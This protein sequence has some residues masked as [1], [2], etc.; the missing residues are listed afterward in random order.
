MALIAIYLLLMA[1]FNAFAAINGKFGLGPARYTILAICTLLV[2]G[3]FGFLRLRRWGWALIVT[4]CLLMA[5]GYFFGFTRTHAPPY[6][7]Q[8]LFALLF[9]LYL[10]RPEVRERLRA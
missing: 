7:V 4:G 10:V 1:M 6:I 9:F 5:V 3:I 2:V 8:G